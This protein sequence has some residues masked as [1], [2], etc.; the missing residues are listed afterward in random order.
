MQY[1][2]YIFLLFVGYSLSTHN[3][4]RRNV[5]LLLHEPHSG[6]YTKYEAAAVQEFWITQ[7]VDHFNRGDSNATW[8][9]VSSD[10]C[11]V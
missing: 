2:L 9:M 6:P 11:V 7:Q 4:Y 3:P 10:I 8:Q 5:E 1:F